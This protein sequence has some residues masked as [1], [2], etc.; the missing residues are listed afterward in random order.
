MIISSIWQ[1]KKKQENIINIVT[2]TTNDRGRNIELSKHKICY[3][4]ATARFNL[5]IQSLTKWRD[6]DV[7]GQSND[8]FF[9][10]FFLGTELEECTLLFI[11]SCKTKSVRRDEEKKNNTESTIKLK[12]GNRRETKRKKKCKAK[13]QNIKKE[14]RGEAKK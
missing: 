6:I 12:K 1:K 9:F 13:A 14:E 4:N 8:M 7:S 2:E 5:D 3:N 10:S 11:L